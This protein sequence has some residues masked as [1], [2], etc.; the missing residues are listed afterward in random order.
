HAGPRPPPDTHTRIFFRQPTAATKRECARD[1]IG[2]FA[3]RAYRRPLTT[4]EMTRLVDFFAMADRKGERFEQSIK[5]TLETVLISPHFLFRGEIQ[6]DP[7]DP[8]SV[9]LIDEYALASRLS[10]FLWSSMPDEELLA[11]AQRGAL[12]KNLGAQV[13]RMLQD[14]KSAA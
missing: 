1:I 9:H 5:L 3:A 7:D 10:Y 2:R 13:R 8:H 6:P 14:P 4:N 12:R 11:L